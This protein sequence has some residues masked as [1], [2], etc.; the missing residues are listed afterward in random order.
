MTCSFIAQSDGALNRK[1]SGEGLRRR[2]LFALLVGLFSYDY[3]FSY[4]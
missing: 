1:T 4:D 3:L 2:I